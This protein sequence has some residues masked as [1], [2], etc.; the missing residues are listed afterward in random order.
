MSVGTSLPVGSSAL[1][2][3]SAFGHL[4]VAFG[5]K[6]SLIGGFADSWNEGARRATVLER[7]ARVCVRMGVGVCVCARC[8]ST[9]VRKPTGA[10]SARLLAFGWDP[11]KSRNGPRLAFNL[12]WMAGWSIRWSLRA[13]VRVRM[14]RHP[15]QFYERLWALSLIT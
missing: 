13:G 14:G 11:G 12:F 10:L 15:C 6:A 9:G 2:Y 8:V 3:P 1:H 4:A 7:D 5:P